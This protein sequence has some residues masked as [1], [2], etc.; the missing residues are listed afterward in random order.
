MQLLIQFYPAIATTVAMFFYKRDNRRMQSFYRRMALSLSARKL[1]VSLLMIAMLIYNFCYLQ[2]NGMNVA[3]WI[4]TILCISMFSFRLAEKSLYV[5]QNRIYLAVAVIPML[6]CVV[7]PG[8]LPISVNL[9][10]IFIGSLFYPSRKLRDRLDNPET[11][12]RFCANQD[13]AIKDYYSR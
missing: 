2:A 12:T 1:F 11:F 7:Q 9:Y 8:L 6:V 13:A 3:L 10:F 4:G 5:L